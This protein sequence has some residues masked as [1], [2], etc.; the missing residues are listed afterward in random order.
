M[1]TAAGG[2]LTERDKAMLEFERT[3]WKYADAKESA[4]RDQ[5]D[6][7]C[8]R[9][10]QVLNTLL[11]QP[12]ALAFDP[13]NV[14]RLRSLRDQRRAQRAARC[15]PGAAGASARRGLGTPRAA[16]DRSPKDAGVGQ[17][18]G[19]CSLVAPIGYWTYVVI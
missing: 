15:K 3:W 19:N 11:D 10:Y 4:I 16:C 14:K 17:V 9:F 5:F 8:A 7:S 6:L 13:L 2:E 12:E 18:V 1:D